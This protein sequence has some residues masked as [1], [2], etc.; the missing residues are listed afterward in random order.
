[1]STSLSV[2]RSNP[3]SGLLR[4]PSGLLGPSTLPQRAVSRP[5]RA[6]SGFLS[7]SLVPQSMYAR[8]SRSLS[9]AAA[10]GGD[11]L[12]Q[13]RYRLV[14]QL[15]LP[16]NQ[17][18]QGL[19]W[20]AIDTRSTA[21]AQV[22][23]REFIM[24]GGEEENKKQQVR[25]TALRLSEAAQHSGFPR[26]IDVFNEQ[27]SYFIVLQHIEGESL[28]SLLRRQG[29]AL[30]ERTVAEYGR[31]LCEMLS[32]LARQ[33][34]PMVH[35]A[36]NPETVIISPDRNRV[37]L[38]HLPL[39]PPKEPGG[40]SAAVGYKAPEQARGVADSSSDLYAVAATLHHAVTGLDPRER[41]AFFYPP[42]R[43]LNPVVSSQM[44]TILAQE[45][46]LSALQRYARVADMQ[47]DL[48]DFLNTP[49]HE[50]EKKPPAS[51]SGDPLKLE[52]FELRR[53]SRQRSFM[54][55]SVFTG[56][57]LLI[58]F[59]LLFFIYIYP[60][61]QTSAKGVAPLATPNP[62]ATFA[63][64]QKALD[65]QWQAEA[66]TYRSKGIGL[67]D[68]RY[69]FDAYDGRP[70]TALNYKKQAA[71]A[72]LR[73]DLPGALNS[74]QQAVTYDPTDGEA[75][76]YYEDL[77]IAI[78][79]DPFVTIILGLPIDETAADLSISRPDLQSAFAFQDY[80]NAH[81]LLPNGLKLRILLAN[82]GA[83]NGDV[84]KLAQFIAQRV[85]I[86]NQDHIV[87]VV[88][89]PKSGESANAI[90]ILTAAKI[91]IISQ[92]ASSTALD[93]IS[94]FF[95]RVNPN[96]TAQGLAEGAFAY[97]DLK[98]RKVLVL[99]DPDDTY[100]QSLADAFTK[101]F[102]QLGGTVL[103]D[104]GDLFKEK[105]T[106]VDEYEAGVVTRARLSAA[107]LIFLPGFDQDAIRLARALSLQAAIYPLHLRNMK[108]LGGDGFDTSL[109]LGSGTGPDALLAQTYPQDMQRLVFTSF[110]SISEWSNVSK[111]KRPASFVNFTTQWDKLYSVASASNPDPPVP[112]STAIMVNDAFGV[113][114]Y[115]MGL[116]KNPLTGE[117][118]RAALVSL[119]SGG[120]QSYK[121]ISGPIAFGPDGNAVNKAVVLLNI[122]PDATGKNSIQLV[123]VSGK[124]S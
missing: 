9:L 121:G 31:Q 10:K 61:L 99:R 25:L 108:I 56:S 53:R 39:L 7:T 80:A 76:I 17:A 22:V 37:H 36:I 88:G 123:R 12:N 52:I 28:A 87:A 104:A 111:A 71:Q 1:R 122:T 65:N 32:V 94:S 119:G 102:T 34:P 117:S 24:P 2:I 73:G 84:A 30:P 40:A 26:V 115:A 105:T 58:L 106:T 45:L 5:L 35:G 112:I 118:L 113:L 95:F 63:A 89:W 82:S 68:G 93:S 98:A 16:D 8:P 86:G 77:Q 74:Y 33:Q 64:L 14:D 15:V 120:V 44:E 38:I 90:S 109:I 72:V 23:L 49:H 69:V 59:G 21:Y 60:L 96:D 42:A 110:S 85:Q 41:I 124:T 91:P 103:N 67:S 75:R 101:S 100:S 18:G 13:G 78:Q 48:V 43:R 114:A 47:K 62:T 79:N 55:L 70:A 19:A 57:C 51:F 4:P 92:T 97:N 27:G 50:E 107:D 116:V 83:E 20:L 3:P 6:P 29:G 66:P 81:S 11:L 54:Q 46:R